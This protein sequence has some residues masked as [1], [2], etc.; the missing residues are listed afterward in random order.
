MKG[1]F[2]S[3]IVFSFTS[4]SRRFFFVFFFSLLFS[5][6]RIFLKGLLSGWRTSVIYLSYLFFYYSYLFEVSSSS[7]YNSVF[8]F[9]SFLYTTYFLYAWMEM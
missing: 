3:Y 7:L 9:L 6:P 4:F 8:F 1:F 2:G 5:H